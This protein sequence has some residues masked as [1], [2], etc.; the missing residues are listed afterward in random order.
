LQE[1]TTVEIPPEDT[2]EKI[3]NAPT[4]KCRKKMTHS[5]SVSLDAH[6]PPYSSSNVSITCSLFL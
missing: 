3:I 5:A 1:E 4:T 6:Q 2:L